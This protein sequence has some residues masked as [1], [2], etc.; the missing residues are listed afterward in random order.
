MVFMSTVQWIIF[1]L[2]LTL[3][4]LAL[5]YAVILK[6]LFK[7]RGWF[8]GYYDWIEP[9]ERNLWDK[10]KTMLFARLY[11]LI[12]FL[13]TAQA[14]LEASGIDWIALIPIPQKYAQW[15]GPVVWITGLLFARL[16]KITTVPLEV[17][18]EQV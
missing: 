3:I 1:F 7:K 18:K 4:L 11:S 9:V 15:V 16:R 2:L 13:I 14:M 10:S 17:K 12:G 5:I 8:Q 6:P